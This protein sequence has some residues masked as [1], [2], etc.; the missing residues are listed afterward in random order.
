ME[1]PRR[2]QQSSGLVV[3]DEV[4]PGAVHSLRPIPH[5]PVPVAKPVERNPTMQGLGP[6]SVPPAREK[7]D[8]LEV[9]TD[10]LLSELSTEHRRRKAAEAELAALK[11]GA[12]PEVDALRSQLSALL[13]AETERA[14]LRA[15]WNALW[16]KVGGGAAT[17]V[18]AACGY[19]AWRLYELQHR[20]DTTEERVTTVKAK[21]VTGRDVQQETLVF[22][23]AQQSYQDCINAQQASATERGTGHKLRSLHDQSGTLW[24][25]QNRPPTRPSPLWA[26]W[27]WATVNDC[28]AEPHV[29][30]LSP[31][32]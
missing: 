20:T 24:Y 9:S 15:A 21:V 31:A 8:S 5:D 13:S 18:V 16:L 4:A 19:G 23:A 7:L 26:T 6:A 3:R 27:S 12:A 29:P 1:P 25:E 22:L 30:T 28:G 17:L 2:K 14:K 10:S 32:P 11:S